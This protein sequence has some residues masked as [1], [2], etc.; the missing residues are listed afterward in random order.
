MSVGDVTRA[1]I[2]RGEKEGVYTS[3]FIRVVHE[4]FLLKS[5]LMATH[6]K[7]NSSYRTRIYCMNINITPWSYAIA[8]SKFANV[9][10]QNVN[11]VSVKQ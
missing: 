10:V 5:T 8:T 1:L 3:A 2:G 7:R 9:V 6:F 11:K 4:E